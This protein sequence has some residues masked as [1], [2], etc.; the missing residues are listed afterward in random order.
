MV[1]VI[2][3]KENVVMT[4][5]AFGKNL[6][7]EYLKPGDYFFKSFID[8]NNNQIWDTGDIEKQIQPEKVFY[9]P[10]KLSIKANW[11]IEESWNH[12]D[13]NMLNKKPVELMKPVKNP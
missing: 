2:D 4:K 5:Q 10:K 9:F 7:F 8:G 11:E 3:A 1:Q 6:R 13:P 12:L